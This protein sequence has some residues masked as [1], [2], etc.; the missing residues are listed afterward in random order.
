MHETDYYSHTRLIGYIDTLT[1][2]PAV[3]R[4]ADRI[5]LVVSDLQD[6]RRSMIFVA[7]GRVC[8]T[9]Y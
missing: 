9:S 2:S 4:I 5:V 8:A 7:C 6:H 3:D 1:R